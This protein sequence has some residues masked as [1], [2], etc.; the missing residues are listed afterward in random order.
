MLS[1]PCKYFKPGG[2]LS[3][4]SP[5]SPV[6]IFLCKLTWYREERKHYSFAEV[7][8]QASSTSETKEA[9]HGFIYHFRLQEQLRGVEVRDAR[10]DAR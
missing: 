9:S 10:H 5:L 2:V 3:S 6:S 1:R 7:Q 4:L 8:V